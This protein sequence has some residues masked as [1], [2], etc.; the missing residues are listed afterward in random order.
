MKKYILIYCIDDEIYF[1]DSYDSMPDAFD[2][3][4]KDMECTLGISMED[5]QKACKNGGEYDEF[6]KIYATKA[7]SYGNNYRQGWKIIEVEV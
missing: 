6:T 4:L 5:L 3:M 2:E 7:L 1:L